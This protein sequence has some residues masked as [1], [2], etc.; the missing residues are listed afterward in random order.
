MGVNTIDWN[1]P[2]GIPVFSENQVHVWLVN[3]SE[4]LDH[5]QKFE[6][7]L[8]KA[9]KKKAAQFKYDD[10][11]QKFVI[12]RGALRI[13]L[14]LYIDKKPLDL[15]IDPNSIGKPVLT[16]SNS[17][18]DLE[19]NISHS[20]EICLVALSQNLEVGVDAEAIKPIADLEEMANSILTKRELIDFHSSLSELKIANFYRLWSAKEAMLKAIGCGL[21]IHP[22]EIEIQEICEK[23][24]FSVEL[25]SNVIDVPYIDLIA[26][27]GLKGYS[28][29]LAVIGKVDEIYKFK[30]TMRFIPV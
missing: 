2:E 26:L 5:S 18:Q 17:Q 27:D 7:F 28:A 21:A 16:K 8:N 14:S 3:I 9:E 20:E 6:H 12:C 4:L 13:I 30:F 25:R 11:R 10:L 24:S 15:N 29:W 1:P 22:R 19:F 23:K